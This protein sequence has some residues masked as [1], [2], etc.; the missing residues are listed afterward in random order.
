MVQKERILLK[1]KCYTEKR[2]KIHYKHIKFSCSF[3]LNQSIQMTQV[4]TAH[5]KTQPHTKMN[6]LVDLFR[7]TYC[8]KVLV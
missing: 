3:K 4:N 1:L 5:T 6:S 8:H 7:L 2:H